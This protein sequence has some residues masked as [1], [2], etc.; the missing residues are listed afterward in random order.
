[1]KYQLLVIANLSLLLYSQLLYF[2]TCFFLFWDTV[3]YFGLTRCH[4]QIFSNA[5][6]VIKI[7]L[8]GR[9][10]SKLLNLKTPDL[11]NINSILFLSF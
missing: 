7:F 8:V 10:D 2:I 3:I 11:Y 5:E 6:H 9:K 4:R 1:M